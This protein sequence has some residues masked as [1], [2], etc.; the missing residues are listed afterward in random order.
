MTGFLDKEEIDITCTKCNRKTKKNIGW[1]KNNREF[2][3]TCGTLIHLDTSQ[4]KNEIS[5][6]ESAYANLQNTFKKL[7]K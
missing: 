6:I 4:F 1:I 3:C 7:S 5:K 2:T